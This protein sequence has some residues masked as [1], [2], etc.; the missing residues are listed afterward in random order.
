VSDAEVS[1]LHVEP[2]DVIVIKSPH[3]RASSELQSL[4]DEL[5]RAYQ[6]LVLLIGPRDCIAKLDPEV[7]ATYGW[8]KAAQ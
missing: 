4:A 6:C 8:V 1:G 2:G 5:S 7:M 3:Y